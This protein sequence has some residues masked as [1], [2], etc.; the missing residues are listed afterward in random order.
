MQL[1]DYFEN[2]PHGSKVIF[3]TSLGITKT[4]LSLIINGRKLPSASLCATIERMTNKK[5]KRKDLRPDLFGG[6]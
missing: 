3:A 6:V 2:K 5:V 1:R 4:W